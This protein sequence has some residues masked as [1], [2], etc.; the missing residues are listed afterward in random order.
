MTA[1]GES[2]SISATNASCAVA[3]KWVAK[4]AGKRL[5]SHASRSALSHG[6]SGYTCAAGTAPSGSAMK[7]AANV[8]ISGN[9]AKGSGLGNSPYFNWSI[10]NAFG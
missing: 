5:E 1:G 7:V 2:Y 6:P 3:Q 9:C 10:Q 4:L 8:Q